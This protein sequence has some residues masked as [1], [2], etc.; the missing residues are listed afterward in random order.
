MVNLTTACTCD[1]QI[2]IQTLKWITWSI[3]FRCPKDC[4]FKERFLTELISKGEK[5]SFAAN[6]MNYTSILYKSIYFRSDFFT[7][8]SW[9]DS[10]WLLEP[11]LIRDPNGDI[12]QK[13]V[14]EVNPVA[15][16]WFTFGLV[17][18]FVSSP[19]SSDFFYIFSSINTAIRH[20]LI[21]NFYPHNNQLSSVH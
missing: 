9:D 3:T 11:Q 12:Y 17:Y 10:L 14:L 6:L 18:I 21:L 2:Q 8:S 16:K 1:A 15:L 5:A 4:V 13:M 19:F 7:W 20:G